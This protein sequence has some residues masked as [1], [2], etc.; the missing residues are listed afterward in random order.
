MNHCKCFC[1]D[2]LGTIYHP[3]LS[4]LHGLTIRFVDSCYIRTNWYLSWHIAIF[5]GYLGLKEFTIRKL[6]G[7]DYTGQLK[8]HDNTLQTSV[9]W[10]GYF[11]VDSCIIAQFISFQLNDVY[12]IP[13]SVQMSIGG[14]IW[15]WILTWVG[16][17]LTLHQLIWKLQGSFITEESENLFFGR[18]LYRDSHQCETHR[19]V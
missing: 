3:I 12:I 14:F 5:I 17:I 18:F 16:K 7:L 13:I 19:V 4:C 9:L 6:Y 1:F 2:S 10:F 15:T 11:F 8:F